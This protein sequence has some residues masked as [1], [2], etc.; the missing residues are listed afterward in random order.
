[1]VSASCGVPRTVQ[2]R[3]A[4][5]TKTSRAARGTRPG[6][7]RTPARDREPRIFAVCDVT[8]GARSVSYPGWAAELVGAQDRLSCRVHV[9]DDDAQL[10]VRLAAERH[11]LSGRIAILAADLETRA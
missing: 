2:R 3:R 11:R 6:A 4:R 8:A 5:S 10:R 7:P 9:P 1:M